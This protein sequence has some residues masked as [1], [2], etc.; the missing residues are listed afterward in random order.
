MKTK[1]VILVFGLL[2]ALF[3]L[4]RL[5]SAIA[6]ER[7]KSQLLRTEGV[8]QS[9]YQEFVE[10]AEAFSRDWKTNASPL[11]STIPIND[12]VS[13]GY[14]RTEDTRE[15]NGLDVIV[16]LTTVTSE[17][18]NANEALARVR[19]PSGRD[20]VLA[21][22]GSVFLQSRERARHRPN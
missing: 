19:L 9:R 17:V 1:Y 2:A 14:I 12:L 8:L 4:I 21:G 10:A 7:E 11:P 6:A 18:N 20:I 15:L 13:R 5:P 16:S 3:I 22:D